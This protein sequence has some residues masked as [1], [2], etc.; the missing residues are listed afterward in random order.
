MIEYETHFFS[1]GLIPTVLPP[2]SLLDHQHKI[3]SDGGKS[4]AGAE[5]HSHSVPGCI[6]V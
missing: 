3:C 5:P 2:Y 1:E 6:A 4:G